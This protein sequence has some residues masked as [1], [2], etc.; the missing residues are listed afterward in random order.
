[1]P[2]ALRAL[3]PITAFPGALTC[4]VAV[5]YWAALEATAL[6]LTSNKPIA[7]RAGNIGSM[8]RGPQEAMLALPR[9]G[10]WTA[11]G[12]NPTLPPVGTVLLWDALPT[13]SAI[14]TAQGITGYNQACVFAPYITQHTYT[15]GLPV[16]I[17]HLKRTCHTISELTIV[18]AA[19]GVFHL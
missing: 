18:R 2:L 1:M 8:P 17:Q 9:S 16:Q 11:N 10:T 3:Q 13:H 14:V 4:H 15:H 12:P 19:G 7:I 5:W 6:G